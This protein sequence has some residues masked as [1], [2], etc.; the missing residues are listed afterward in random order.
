MVQKLKYD[1]FISYRHADTDLFAAKKL[2]RKLETFHVPHAIAKKSGKKN[3]K[4]V[5]RDQEEL[6]VG[7]DLGDNIEKALAESEFLLVI[8]T[9]RTPE[10]YWVQKEIETFIRI[11]DREHVLAVL[12]E[13]EPGESFP[14]QLLED[15]NGSP[16]EPLAADIRGKTKAQINKKLK[17]EIM[18]LAAPLLHC[19]YD[20][21]RQRHRER[22]I[23]K[24]VSV[25]AAAAVFA[26]AFAAYS[27]H[28]ARVIR[29]NYEEKLKSQ[30]KYL[31]ETSLALLKDGDRRAAALVALEALPSE[32]NER[33][34]AAAA[35]YALSQALYS[36][37]MGTKIQMDRS[38]KHDFPVKSFDFTAD[39]SKL[40]SI[41][42]GASVYVWDA[43]SKK[44]LAEIT[45]E[46]NESGYL[47]E[48]LGA[49]VCKEHILICDENGIRAVDF[50]GKQ[51]WRSRKE[52]GINYCKFDEDLQLAVCVSNEEAV[53]FDMT[54]GTMRYTMKNR[55]KDSYCSAM[56]F[57]PGKDK[58]AVAH[59]TDGQEEKG[60]VSIYDFKTKKITD[61]SA[62]ASYISDLVFAD[63]NTLA[64]VGTKD[65]ITDLE[66]YSGK[67]TGYVEILDTRKKSSLWKKKFE[68]QIFGINAAGTQLKSCCYEDKESG[69]LHE[70][71]VLSVDNTVYAWDCRSGKL[72]A[73]T[74]VGS[75]ILDMLVSD[76]SSIGYL[77]ESSG[78]ID[79]VNL[80]DGTI[81]S[82]AA[83]DTG[84]SLKNIQVKNG[85]LV[86]RSYESPSLT[87]MEYHEGMGMEKLES[88]ESSVR[89]IQVSA[90]ESYYAVHTYED[91]FYFYDSMKN[92]LRGQWHETDGRYAGKSGFVN[93][94]EYV[95][96]VPDGT[97]VFCDAAD[98]KVNEVSAGNEFSTAKCYFTDSA[99]FALVY[100][101]T[102]YC[103]A[104]LQTKKILYKGET[105]DDMSAAVLSEDGEWIYC[106]FGTG[107]V[108]AVRVKTGETVSMPEEYMV[109]NNGEEQD[110]FAVSSDGSLLAVSCRDGILRVLDTE[111]KE[112]AAEIP[113]TGNRR[114]FIR[115]SEDCAEVM[116]QGD[117]Y[118]FRVYRLDDKE[119][120][121]ISTDQYYQLSSIVTDDASVVTMVTSEDMVILNKGDYERTAQID[122]GKAYMPGHGKIFCSDGKSLY[123]FP[124]MTLEML[125]EEAGRQFPGEKLTDLEKIQYHTE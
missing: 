103:V 56:A 25:T 45:P 73:E 23:R 107:G 13:G 38:L 102:A 32:E 8:C 115:F 94:R 117:D 53:F 41:D 20:D 54:D 7:S 78:I 80:L 108:A 93:D 52:E 82:G 91:G 3:I 63:E 74:S 16:V 60:H 19:S 120:S 109:L 11:H 85:I 86:M 81:Y 42:Q 68:Y 95:I 69:K 72:L 66:Q 101:E 97:L 111:T 116:L 61:I 49:A 65:S 122:G 48:P 29:Q 12:A 87:V 22:R 6:P 28:N 92:T 98:G 124:Y 114:R 113:F 67:S 31:A 2:H 39:G 17:T 64:T 50:D 44:K 15:E 27:T 90:E 51:L 96:S 9:P 40:V 84:K 21:L 112:T 35:Q 89:E 88:Y 33:P 76:R 77:A 34:Y 119:F 30:S 10:S 110:A 14:K 83:I 5:F 123:A 62:S 4:R 57:G 125:R 106:S 1:A 100:Q 55:T 105:Q 79:A 104:D 47:V 43:K 46:I 99:E 58:F 37:D 118:Y 70:E 71:I 36:Y 75:G 121:H 24:M 59:L 18:R 26:L